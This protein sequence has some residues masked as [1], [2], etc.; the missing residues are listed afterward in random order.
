MKKYTLVDAAGNVFASGLDPIITMYEL[1]TQD[2]GE[3]FIRGEYDE[4]EQLVCFRLYY[5]NRHFMP[6][7]P[8]IFFSKRTDFEKALQDIAMQVIKESA[9]MGFSLHAWKDKEF[10]KMKKLT[11]SF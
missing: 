9:C 3:Y 11:S 8:T 10:R 7:A 5:S 1:L 4:N 2:G 6:L